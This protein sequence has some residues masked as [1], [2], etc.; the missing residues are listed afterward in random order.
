MYLKGSHFFDIT[1]SYLYIFHTQ[2]AFL[3]SSLTFTSMKTLKSVSIPGTPIE[4]DS[5]A[6]IR[7]VYAVKKNR[8]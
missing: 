3:C 2:V 8:F 5:E 4:D 6:D 1:F 7:Y